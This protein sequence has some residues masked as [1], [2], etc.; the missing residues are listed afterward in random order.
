VQ[1]EPVGRR[2]FLKVMGAVGMSLS[3]A[4]PSLPE[5]AFGLQPTSGAV[6]EQAAGPGPDAG[7]KPKYSIK[8]G[9][10]GLDHYHIMGMTAAV[11]RGGG[12]LVSF[13]SNLPKA[14]ADFQKIYPKAKLA[15]SEDEILEDPSLKLIAG[16]PIPR[17]R[18]PLGIR[19]MKQG[20]DFLSDKPGITTLEQLAEVR[21]V[22]AE[23]GKM[24]AIMYS[25][26]LEVRRRCRRV[27]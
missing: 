2:S 22:S 1:Q 26:R 16:A 20:K 7:A 9:V 10:I 8:F 21:K 5:T 23:T 27:T 4:G 15:R 24:F 3:Q 17:L 19:A 14:I 25:E 12:E 18:A 13:Y 6:V 11:I